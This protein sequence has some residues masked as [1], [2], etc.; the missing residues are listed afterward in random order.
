MKLGAV[1]RSLFSNPSHREGEEERNKTDKADDE[2]ER[3]VSR[4]AE[5][6]T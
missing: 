1:M 2:D 6:S 5:G 4:Y 3:L